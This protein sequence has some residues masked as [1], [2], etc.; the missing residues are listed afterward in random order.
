MWPLGE[1]EAGGALPLGDPGF[2]PGAFGLRAEK[3]LFFGRLRF[4]ILAVCLHVCQLTDAVVV[5]V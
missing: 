1:V 4:F 2:E 3:G 5:G